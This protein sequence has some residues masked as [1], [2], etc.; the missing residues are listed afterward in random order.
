MRVKKERNVKAPLKPDR[1]QWTREVVNTSIVRMDI[2]RVWIRLLRDKDFHRLNRR[3]RF[4][5][6]DCKHFLRLLATLDNLR[7]IRN[8]SS[9]S[10]KFLTSAMIP[11]SKGYLVV[12]VMKHITM[13][14]MK[15]SS[16]P[17][18]FLLSIYS[19]L[20]KRRW[21][22]WVTHIHLQRESWMQQTCQVSHKLMKFFSQYY[23]LK[24]VGKNQAF[25]KMDCFTQ[26]LN[27]LKSHNLPQMKAVSSKK[28]HYR[29]KDYSLET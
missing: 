2:I 14:I 26:D 12:I 3:I 7:T 25:F 10:P 5:L 27:S 28:Q 1:S 15:L 13:V 19:T 22:D 21:I 20:V 16:K 18:C 4:L 24:V 17:K 9:T 23:H 29:K 11:D 6:K 8:M